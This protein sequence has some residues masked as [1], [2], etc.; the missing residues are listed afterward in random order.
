MKEAKVNDNVSVILAETQFYS[1]AGGQVG[2]KGLIKT[3]VG[4]SSFDY[5]CIT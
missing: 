3:Q 2:D 5:G 1:E 4:N